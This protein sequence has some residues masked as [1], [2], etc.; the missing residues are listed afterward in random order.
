MTFYD[1]MRQSLLSDA[2]QHPMPQ[3]LRENL[4]ARLKSLR[5]DDAAKDRKEKSCGF[6]E[7]DC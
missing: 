5:E 2:E 4:E 3:R 6:A 1:L 7:K